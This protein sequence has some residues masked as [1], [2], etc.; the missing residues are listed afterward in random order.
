MFSLPYGMDPSSRGRCFM[1]KRS[2][3]FPG[4]RNTSRQGIPSHSLK[5]NLKSVKSSFQFKNGFLAT[6]Y[7]SNGNRFYRRYASDNPVEDAQKLFRSLGRGGVQRVIRDNN[8]GVKG[9][10][11]TMLGGDVITYRPRRSSDNS[12]VV[13]INIS[14]RRSGLKSQ[15][16]HFYHKEAK[17]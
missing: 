3:G 10:T 14:S 12:T 15:K 16:I 8:G 11:R 9:W 4:L 2:F 7:K 6:K 5:G 1:G 17:L 13:D